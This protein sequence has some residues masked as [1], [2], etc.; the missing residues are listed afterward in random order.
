MI[1][2]EDLRETKLLINEESFKLDIK[3]WNPIT[4]EILKDY[5][6]WKIK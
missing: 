1:G 5:V 4:I 2:D 6:E 3:A